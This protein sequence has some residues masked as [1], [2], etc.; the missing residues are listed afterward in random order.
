[1]YCMVSISIAAAEILVSVHQAISINNIA[2]IPIVSNQYKNKIG[3]TTAENT[4]RSILSFWKK[5]TQP[6][7]G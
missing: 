1:M 3:I 5:M 4:L 6:F 7:K 2:L